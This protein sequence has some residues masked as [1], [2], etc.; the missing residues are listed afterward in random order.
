MHRLLSLNEA[1][2]GCKKNSMKSERAVVFL[3]RDG[4]INEDLGYTFKVEDLRIKEGVSEGLKLL[5]D[6]SYRLIVITNQSGVARG[7]YKLD[8]VHRFHR[9]IQQE[10][11]KHS[12]V[13]ID[14]FYVCPHLAEGIVPEYSIDC[15]CRKPGNLNIEIAIRDLNLD[16]RNGFMIG[17]R[18][19]DVLAGKSSQLKTILVGSR[20]DRADF[21]CDRFL[22]ACAWIVEP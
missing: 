13:W 22:D 8:D 6:A 1:E 16:R 12:G 3:D 4:V 10:L 17:D 18:V 20:D 7:M 21:A 14:H 9:A 15:D 19:S 5:R 11:S 2:S